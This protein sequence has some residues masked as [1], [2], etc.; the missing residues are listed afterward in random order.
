[1]LNTLDTID[2][3]LSLTDANWPTCALGI[4]NIGTYGDK[5]TC[6]VQEVP[7][8]STPLVVNDTQDV[9]RETYMPIWL[10][11]GIALPIM[12]TIGSI[13]YFCRRR[14][15]YPRENEDIV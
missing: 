2:T 9:L 14:R 11:I 4:D 10:S 3:I 15:L 13:Y 6:G 12:V 1:M 5:S 7:L 8:E